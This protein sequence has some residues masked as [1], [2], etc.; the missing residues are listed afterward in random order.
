MSNDFGDRTAALTLPGKS[1][2]NLEPTSLNSPKKVRPWEFS[3][4]CKIRPP[5]R[6]H[7]G[8]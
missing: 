3:I 6:T 7:L 5:L 4:L 2:L 1:S 8:S